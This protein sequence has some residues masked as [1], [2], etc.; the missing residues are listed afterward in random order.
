MANK[1]IIDQTRNSKRMARIRAAIDRESLG[2]HPEQA[3]IRWEAR[4]YMPGEREYVRLPGIQIELLV[5]S[6]EELQWA[7]DAMIWGIENYDKQ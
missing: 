6:D 2:P 4:V 7:R 1:T 3:T 5:G